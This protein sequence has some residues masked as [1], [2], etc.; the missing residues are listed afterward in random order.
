MAVIGL[1][2][3][4]AGLL[5]G[6]GVSVYAGEGDC[7]SAFVDSS[8]AAEV[9]DTFTGGSG[10]LGCPGA[11]SEARALPLALLVV[12]VGVAAGGMVVVRT[13]KG[14]TSARARRPAAK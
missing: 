12:G 3:V 2:L 4:A 10:D 13:P 8:A 11:R 9:E 6:F 5:V 1:S 7:G 14:S